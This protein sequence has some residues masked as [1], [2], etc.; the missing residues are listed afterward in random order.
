MRR[1]IRLRSRSRAVRS[2]NGKR[3]TYADQIGKAEKETAQDAGT[4]TGSPE[5]R[6]QLEG[7]D[8]GIIEEKA[9]S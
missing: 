3:L 2:A 5:D 6:G 4:E 7:R 9:S 1:A 8:Q